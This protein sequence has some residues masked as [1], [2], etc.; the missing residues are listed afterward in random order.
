MIRN[1]AEDT[2][3]KC[4]ENYS[5]IVAIRF[6]TFKIKNMASYYITISLNCSS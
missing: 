6:K 1:L 4:S 3:M 5:S 2:S